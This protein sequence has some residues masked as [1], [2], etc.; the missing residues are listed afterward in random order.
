MI[1]VPLSRI[2]ILLFTAL[3][4]LAA[5]CL[6]PNYRIDVHSH[7]IPNIWREALVDAGYP[8]VNGTL[9]VEGFPVPEWTIKDHID[10]M[11]KLG[12]GYATLSITAPGVYFLAEE[13]TKA[14]KLAR[15]INEALHN[16]T[17]EY[18]KRLGALCLLPLPSVKDAVAEIEYCLD[19]LSFDGV[20][21][22]TNSAGLYLGSESLDAIFEALS[23]RNATVFVHP[24]EPGCH[25]ATMGYPA[26]LTEYPFDSVR[27][28]QHM[29]LTGQRARH[30]NVTII[31]PHGG[32]AIPYVANR[33]ASVSSVDVLGGLNP[34]E[35]MQELKGY[36]F[37]TASSTS[38]IQLAALKEFAGVEK[39]LVGTDYPYVPAVGAKLG[40][41]AIPAN[42][43]FTEGDMA[44]VNHGNALSIFPRIVAKLEKPRSVRA[45]RNGDKIEV[46]R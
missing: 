32:G 41:E 12:V 31:F 7:A 34:L 40:I 42:G 16:Y 36:Y 17:L 18:P 4:A 13:P 15:E 8:I 5:H 28:M 11:D 20:A 27:A 2:A 26:P 6:S 9:T 29:L 45:R 10:T 1:T 39:I 37:D 33:I 44:R 19:T 23:A 14:K 22:Y 24:A 21:L 38:K 25:D 35:T 43:E 3:H 46:Y 30:P